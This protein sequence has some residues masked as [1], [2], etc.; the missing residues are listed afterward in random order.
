MEVVEA[1]RLLAAFV[2][3]P[4]GV[5]DVTA[6]NSGNSIHA[7][8]AKGKVTIDVDG[9][10][11]SFSRSQAKHVTIHALGGADLITI[12]DDSGDYTIDGGGGADTFVGGDG[13][14]TF[15]GGGGID[16]ADYSARTKRVFLSLDG[17]ANDG[18]KNEGDYL[19]G[20]VEVLI[21]GEGND[22]LAGNNL[23]NTLRGNGGDDWLIAGLGD[24]LLDGG[25]GYD[26]ADY[27][28][29]KTSLDVT[30]S[31]GGTV[32]SGGE[33]DTLAP[34]TYLAILGGR[35][36][37]T[38][39]ITTVR[40][41]HVLADGGQGNDT[42]GCFGD[43]ESAT[44]TLHGGAG[45]DT[46]STGTELGRDNFFP[47][48]DGGD[49]I[50]FAKNIVIF[51]GGGGIDTFSAQNSS[52]IAYI[53]LRIM[54]T[55]ENATLSSF[56]GGTL[57]GNDLDN[58]LSAGP[59]IGA[60]VSVSINGMG[61]DDTLVGTALRDTF[62]GGD[63]SDTVDYSGRTENLN[64]SLDGLANDGAFNE[65]DLVSADIENVIGGLGNDHITGNDDR[66]RLDGGAG[67][68]TLRGAG[69][70][71]IL[72]GGA[73]DDTADTDNRDQRNG[74]EHLV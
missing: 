45:N 26:T 54:P 8:F 25:D 24:D 37:D 11:Q 32:K 59:D 2:T 52:N 27:T 64:I 40:N 68:D 17:K 50:C 73:G 33:T 69:A 15:M 38:F 20:D 10:S 67:N 65:N 72:I 53:D 62:I 74:I 70:R 4:H 9:V 60:G 31:N 23:A 34:D 6:S 21:G 49:D 48:G 57:I 35:G 58:Y 7:T 12:D 43:Q 19:R 44:I 55:T 56:Y 1:R 18:E 5:L 47:F 63:G 46:L 71:D 30:F 39:D 13:A 22:S 51:Q 14:E 36:A 28:S 29:R 41:T 66:N 3:S 61:G 16:T 42:L